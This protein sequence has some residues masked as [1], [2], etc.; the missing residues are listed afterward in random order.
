MLWHSFKKLFS[1]ESIVLILCIVFYVIC[2]IVNITCL[3]YEVTKIPCPACGMG[4]ALTS[5][6]KGNVEQY[7][8]YN[9]MAFPVALVFISEL[10]IKRFGNYKKT[11][12]NCSVL[13]LTINM[14][15]YLIRINFVF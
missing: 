2:R 10:F 7:I 15:Y 13:I 3:F 5:L 8:M 9:I 14:L 12:H 4:R 1:Y 11:V 6:F